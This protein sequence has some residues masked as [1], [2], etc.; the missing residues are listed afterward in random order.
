M[1][2]GV[3]AVELVVVRR[4]GAKHAGWATLA[5]GTSRLVPIPNYGDRL[6][7]DLVHLA[8]EASVPLAWGF[9][10]LVATGASFDA[11]AAAGARRPRRIPPQDDPLV[12]AHLDELLEA[13][14]LVAAFSG[15]LGDE[16]FADDDQ[17]VAALDE[18]AARTGR[19]LPGGL[20]RPERRAEVA[21]AVRDLDR[22]W[23]GVPVDG[24][25]E[26]TWPEPA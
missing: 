25:L 13:E 5:D 14:A 23:R 3:A 19:P 1:P 9:W 10:G 26:L 17:L 20:D 21:D 16:P 11:P 22:R 15:L 6:P 12:A 24:R 4:A 7:H 18:A 8:V 2:T